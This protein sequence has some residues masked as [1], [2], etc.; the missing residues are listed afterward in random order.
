VSFYLLETLGDPNDMD[1]CFLDNF[2]DGL[3]PKSWRIGEGERFGDLYPS[4]ARIYM[5]DE[6]PGIKLSALL[7]TT[8]NMIVAARELKELV[9]KH[10]TNEIEYL[11]F[12]LYDHRKRVY[13]TDYCLINPI[14]TFD[15]L[16][17]NAS[18]FLRKKS[19]PSEIISVTTP[20]LDKAKVKDAPQLFRMPYSPTNYVLGFE[21]AK[22]IH[23]RK[24]TNI[25]W[26]KLSFA[27]GTT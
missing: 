25:R 15:C 8:R 14:G 3:E 24:L 27:D 10:C 5:N 7:G 23:D 18:E 16:D 1:L 9:E 13:S 4:D 11:P 12:T 20:I 26:K 2:V 21:L 6:N 19:N 17:M 22:D